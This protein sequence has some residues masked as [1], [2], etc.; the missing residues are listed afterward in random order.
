MIV[1]S[2]ADGLVL[3]T[4]SAH[5]LLAFQLAEHWGNRITPRPSPRAEVLA[6]VLLHDAGWDHWDQYPQWDEAE[7]PLGF[8]TWPSGEEREKLWRE[9]LAHATQRGRYVEYLVG[10]HV[11]HLAETYSP[12]QHQEFVRELRQHLQRLREQL[13]QEPRFRQIQATGQDEVNRHIMRVVDA[14]A[15]YLLRP[16]ARWEIP[17]VPLKEGPASLQLIPAGPNLFRLHPWPFVGS[18]LTVRVEGYR[19]PTQAP[20]PKDT[21]SQLPRVTLAFTLLRLGK[22]S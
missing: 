7:G 13:V 12:N 9:S 15:I 18:R 6:A 20:V 1:R 11:L 5:A 19:L 16:P 21:W 8:E 22:A 14:L 3:V 10:Y 17:E 2:T 4:Q